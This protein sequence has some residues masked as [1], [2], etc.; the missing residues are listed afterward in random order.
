M[1]TSENMEKDPEDPQPADGDTQMEYSGL[2]IQ[3]KHRS[4]NK[5]LCKGTMSL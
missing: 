4:K 2:I 1:Q 3:P 5:K